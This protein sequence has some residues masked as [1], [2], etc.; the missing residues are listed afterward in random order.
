MGAGGDD[1]AGRDPAAAAGVVDRGDAKLDRVAGAQA[2]AIG[3]RL[4]VGGNLDRRMGEVHPLPAR[5]GGA[6]NQ[7]AVGEIVGQHQQPVERAEILVARVDDLDRRMQRRGGE[8]LV[9]RIGLRAGRQRLV[10]AEA[11][12]ALD[13]DDLEPARRQARR[14]RHHGRGIDRRREMPAQRRDADLPP[15]DLLAE[16]GDHRIL[17]LVGIRLGLRDGVGRQRSDR[18]TLAGGGER[19]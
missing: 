16:L 3:E 13:A 1:R 11:D 8:H 4:A 6:V 2:G 12:L 10:E 18:R 19:A 9:A 14:A 7:R 15:A 17:D 5:R